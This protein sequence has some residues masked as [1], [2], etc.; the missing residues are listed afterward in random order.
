MT[1]AKCQIAPDRDTVIAEIEIAAPPDRVFRAIVDRDQ[2]LQW[3]GGEA[4]EITHWEL[5]PHVGGKWRLVSRARQGTGAGQIYD[6]H[7]EVVEINPPY[8]LEYT[9][10]ASWHPDPNHGTIVRW[11]LTP[12]ETGTIL[13]VTHSKLAALDLA[14]DYAQGWPGLVQ[15]IKNFVERKK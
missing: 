10:L 9:W 11:E 12:T 3:G 5:E 6:H 8:V 4:F 13:K 1:S 7:G 2:A 15:Q 14:K